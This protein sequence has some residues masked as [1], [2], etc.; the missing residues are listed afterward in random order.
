[1]WLDLF[2]LQVYNAFEDALKLVAV[3]SNKL[4]GM[5]SGVKVEA[6]KAELRLLST[7][8]QHAKLTRMRTRNEGLIAKL[9]VST[10]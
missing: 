5:S 3:E 9:L 1:M 6:Q 2:F 8:L 10:G 4:S 7:Y